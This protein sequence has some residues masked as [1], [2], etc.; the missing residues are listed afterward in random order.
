[1]LEDGRAQRTLFVAR[2]LRD[3][4]LQW[5]ITEGLN[6]VKAFNRAN[7]VLYYGKGALSEPAAPPHD[8]VTRQTGARSVQNV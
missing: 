4:E 6:V 7:A 8:A 2:Y 1:M 3:R 5:E